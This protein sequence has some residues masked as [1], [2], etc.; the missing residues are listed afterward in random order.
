VPRLG[1]LEAAVPLFAICSVAFVGLIE[2]LVQGLNPLNPI[3]EN[4]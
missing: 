3:V 1:G 2:M 4:S